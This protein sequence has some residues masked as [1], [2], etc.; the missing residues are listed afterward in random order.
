MLTQPIGLKALCMCIWV[1]VTVYLCLWAP[2]HKRSLE[3]S[4]WP[5]DNVRLVDVPDWSLHCC[6][7]E[8]WILS[9]SCAPTTLAFWK[10][11]HVDVHIVKYIKSTESCFYYVHGWMRE[12]EGEERVRRLVTEGERSGEAEREGQWS[13]WWKDWGVDVKLED[14]KRTEGLC[15]PPLLPVVK[16]KHTVTL[17]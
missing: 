12:C 10:S 14:R 6:L 2:K 11:I 3:L 16:T 17:Y 8:N 1:H 7:T 5:S 4:C 15:L 13:K 9:S